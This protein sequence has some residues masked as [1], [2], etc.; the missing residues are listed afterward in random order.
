MGGVGERINDP[1]YSFRFAV[2]IDSMVVGGFSEVSGVEAETEYEEYKEGGENTFVH[3]LPK[4]TKYG[5]LVL[6]RGMTDPE[7]YNW[8]RDVILGKIDVKNIN[9]LLLDSAKQPN[10]VRRWGFEKAFPVKWSGPEFK[11]DSSAVAIEAVEFAHK[12]LSIN[13]QP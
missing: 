10:E 3:K 9:I 2:E 5:N 7:L 12:G 1:Y 8:Y 6:R 11:A 4:G 13:K